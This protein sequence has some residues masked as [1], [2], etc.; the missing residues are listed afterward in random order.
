MLPG[1]KHPLHEHRIK[2]ETFQLLYGGL[3]V[4][5][6][7]KL[8]LMKPGD[9]QTILRGEKHSFTSDIGAIFEEVSSTHIKSDSYY[10]DEEINKLDPIERKTILKKW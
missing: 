4:N 3:E 8:V 10:E 7:G 6:E 1:Q 9:I 5:I 2:E